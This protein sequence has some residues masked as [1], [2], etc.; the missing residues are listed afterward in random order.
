MNTNIIMIGDAHI[1]MRAPSSRIDDYKAS[2]EDKINQITALARDNKADIIIPGDIFSKIQTDNEF[3]VWFLG[4]FKKMNEYST[5]YVIFGNHD[6]YRNQSDLEDKTPVK[7]LEQAGLVH[8]LRGGSSVKIGNLD[9]QGYGY[10]D[11][12]GKAISNNTLLVAHKFYKQSKYK[13]HNIKPSDLDSLGYKYALLGHDHIFYKTE[14]TD[15]GCTVFRP[16]SLMR[17]TSHEYNFE[18]TVNVQIF[19]TLTY[20][21][22]LIPLRIKPMV[23]VVSESILVNKENNLSEGNFDNY[24][25]EVDSVVKSTDMSEEIKTLC[26]RID[27]K[28]E[29]SIEVKEK[30]KNLIIN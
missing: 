13:E 28:S 1:Q 24:L 27:L 17:G 20:E 5:V 29:Y 18:R 16:G 4:L 26:N 25:S 22:A 23:E 19:N 8:V 14:M 12:L 7:I 21:S 30:L 11:N 6:Y 9:I 10:Y 3:I 2:I 15:G